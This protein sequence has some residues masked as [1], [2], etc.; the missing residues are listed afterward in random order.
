MKRIQIH[1]DEDLDDAAEAEAARRGISK[2]ALIR[3]S[4]A[5]ELRTESGNPLDPWANI[6]GWLD[7]DPVED[8]DEA[9]YGPRK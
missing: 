9:V 5:H 3:T 2:A 7:D 8:I 6:S 4:L 1:V